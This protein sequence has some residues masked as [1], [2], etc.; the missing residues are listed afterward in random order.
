MQSA[1]KRLAWNEVVGDEGIP[2][3]AVRMVSQGQVAHRRSGKAYAGHLGRALRLQLV[4]QVQ[5][6]QQSHSSTKGVPCQRTTTLS[7]AASHSYDRSHVR[8]ADI[9]HM[10]LS[11]LASVCKGRRPLMI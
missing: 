1:V 2:A 9:I 11:M 5:A 3:L 10:V 6:A 7:L 8:T 4:Q